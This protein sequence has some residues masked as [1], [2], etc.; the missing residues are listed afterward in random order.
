MKSVILSGAVLAEKIE[1]FV[2]N[3]KVSAPAPPVNVSIPVSPV[4]VSAPDPP[5][6]ESLP[7]EPVMLSAVVIA[8]V[9][10]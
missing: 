9:S 7:V 2:L 6:I 1:P 5:T 8:A 4:I 3:T 10:V